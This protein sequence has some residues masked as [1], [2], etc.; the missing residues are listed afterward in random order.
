[1]FGLH[2]K[3]KRREALFAEGLTEEQRAVV[4]RDVPYAARLSDA[5]RRELEGHARV[6]LDEKRF[7]GAGGLTLTEE[8]KL[9]IAA[10]ACILLLHRARVPLVF[11]VLAL[12]LASACA[13]GASAPPVD[14][15][16]DAARVYV[17]VPFTPTA[18]TR[19]YCGPRDDDAI[20]ARI[21]AALAALSIA[22]KVALMH[23]AGFALVD[24]M[25]RVEGSARL[26]LPGLRMQDGPRGLSSS[27]GKRATAF[28][29]AMMRGATW[30]PALEERVGRAMA[31]EVRATGGDVLLAPTLNILRHPRWGRAQ[32]TYSEDGFHLGE[33]GVAF[34]RGVQSGGVLASVKHFAANSIE[35]TRYTVDVQLDE[36]TLRE[37]YLPHFRRAVVEAHVAS[38]MTAYNRVNGLHCDEQTHLLSEILKGEWQF[39]G[40]VESDWTLGTHGD[41]QSVQA[42]LDVEMPN[43]AHFRRLPAAVADGTLD[44]PALDDSVRRI[45]RAQLCFGL[46]AR[47]PTDDPSVRESAAHLALAREV[48]ERGLVL[49][50]NEPADGAAAGAPPVLPFAPG[51]RRI[52]VLGRAADVENIG[53]TGSSRV[54]PS[55]VITAL[56]GLV[57]RAGSAVTVTHVGGSTLGAAAEA[58][59]RAADVV[60]VVTGLLA[61]DEGEL[62]VGGGDRSS[63][64]LAPSEV[65]LIHAVAAIHPAVVVVLEGG[66]T[67]LT[68]DWESDVE[69]LIF[70]FYPGAQGGAALAGLLFGDVSPSGR[71]PF[72]IPEREADL[73]AFDDVSPTVT[74]GYF[75]GY[76]HLAHEGLAPRHAFGSGLSYA[77]F[78]YSELALG[79]PTLAADGVLEATVLVT[80]TGAVAG[81]E[82]VQLYVAALGSRVERAP[83]DLRAFTQ[84][85][86]APGASAR[87]SLRVS[88][89]DLRFWDVATS[90]WE[91]EA[92]AYEARVGAS[93]GDIRLVAPF[94]VE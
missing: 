94:T 82:T 22:E 25:W 85:L 50:R 46:D 66:A 64:A 1:V 26:G 88:A 73:P 8:L 37:I 31:D 76:R 81:R 80:N 5:D 12:L 2:S 93:S 54:L 67:L 43:D 47:A 34:I 70:A 6:F 33:L 21:T 74:Y 14:A 71:L 84:V 27:T 9:T 52:V 38:V 51:V 92:L 11:V 86:L 58:L 62:T 89:D 18:A 4:L 53:D 77:R 20:E 57:A 17:P 56:E 36:R 60:V 59:V 24:G 44:E 72:S 75:H 30:D 68:S 91:L 28:P 61:A 41:V 79:A 65:A 15:A 16:V 55:D 45:L 29:V 42:G 40:F 39:A 35:T 19:A 87:V 23:G 3:K 63:L 69:G 78:E 7:E 49:L 13:P 90:R 32:E 10:Q 83:Q 48:A